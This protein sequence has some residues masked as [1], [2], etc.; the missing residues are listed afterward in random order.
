M[1]PLAS[2]P[3]CPGLIWTG[4]QIGCTSSSGW[5]SLPSHLHKLG[6]L[7]V[8]RTTSSTGCVGSSSWSLRSAGRAHR[9]P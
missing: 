2:A 5:P 1:K 8:P 7:R 3:P 6:V 9:A 4:A